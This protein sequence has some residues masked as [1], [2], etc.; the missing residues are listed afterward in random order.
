MKQL[1]LLVIFITL[2]LVQVSQAQSINKTWQI[3]LKESIPYMKPAEQASFK[4]LDASMLDMMKKTFE[5]LRYKFSSGGVL[6]VVATDAGNTATM[7]TP[8]RWTKSGN[9]LTL[10]PQGGTAQDKQVFT[11]VKLTSKVLVLKKEEGDY[12]AFVAVD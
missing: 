4:Q 8:G 11:I 12:V 1:C 2:G 6:E 10:F 7:P 5:K 9:T 3:S